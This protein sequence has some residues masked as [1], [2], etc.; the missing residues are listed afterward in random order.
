MYKAEKVTIQF[1]PLGEWSEP[2]KIIH[3]EGSFRAEHED[4]LTMICAE[5][6]KLRVKA[7]VLEVDVSK[8]NDARGK[9]CLSRWVDVNTPRVRLS[10]KHPQMGDLQYPC[11]TYRNWTH[12]VRAIA[13]TLEAQRSMER[14]GASTKGQQYRG[15]QQLP[16]PEQPKA[17]RDGPET[18]EEAAQLV[19]ELSGNPLEGDA[20]LRNE[21]MYRFMFK[22]AVK[23]AHP[24][25]GGEASDFRALQVAKELLEKHFQA[26]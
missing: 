7:A 22:D 20:A 26:L 11:N 8:R 13:L 5:L 17:E 25:L 6:G 14:Y 19:A 15:W 24:D 3:M 18:V 23:Q 21:K 1:E 10:F 4:T 9:K 16:P 12:N 2:S